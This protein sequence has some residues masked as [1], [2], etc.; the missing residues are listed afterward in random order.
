MLILISM[1]LLALTSLASA[2]EILY[3]GIV[4]P[5]QWPP[6][7]DELTR[8]PRPAPYLK[9]PP[10]VIPIDVGRQLFVDDFLIETTTMT[11]TYHQADYYAQNPVLAPET[12]WEHTGGNW[13]AAPFSGGAWY[14]PNDDLFKLWYRGGNAV[15][16][17]AQDNCEGNHRD[18]VTIWLDHNASASERFKYFATEY[19][20]PAGLT[21]RTSPDG[22]HWSTPQ[23]SVVSIWG[24]R[25]TAVYNPFRDVWICSQRTEDA[26]GRRTRSYVEGPTAASM[27]AE[28]TYNELDQVTGKSVHWVSPDFSGASH[29]YVGAGGPGFTGPTDTVG[30]SAVRTSE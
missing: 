12:A 5:D 27:M 14:D 30:Q 22:I 21:Y 16:P 18:T 11:Q 9:N 23:G 26:V 13:F 17:L 6:K 25:T 20:D 1:V 4:L 3:N 28:V 29:G 19:G 2:G 7:F 10:A 15:Y 24:D 8:E